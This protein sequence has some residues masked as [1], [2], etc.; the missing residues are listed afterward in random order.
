VSLLAEN[1]YRVQHLEGAVHR[2][3]ERLAEL[4]TR[5]KSLRQEEITE[6]IE[7]ILLASPIAVLPQE[8]S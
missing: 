7:M 2:L 4:S 5:A 3:N 8:E 1:Q 6:E